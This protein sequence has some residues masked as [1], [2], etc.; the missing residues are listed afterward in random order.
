MLRVQVPTLPAL[1]PK[2]TVQFKSSPGI[3][4]KKSEQSIAMKHV[5]NTSAGQG[6][7]EPVKR[8]NLL[9]IASALSSLALLDIHP[10]LLLLDLVYLQR[11]SLGR[12]M[13]Q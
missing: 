4:C 6:A 11:F 7:Q 9:L 8:L 5:R 2:S 1:P 10:V 3:A 13:Q 12:P